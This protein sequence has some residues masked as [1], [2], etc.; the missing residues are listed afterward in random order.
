MTW[1]ALEIELRIWRAEG[2]TL[3]LWWRDDDAVAETAALEQLFDLSEKL[4]LPLHLAVIPE[5]ADTGLAH[6]CAARKDIVPLVHGWTHRNHALAGM[7]KAEFGRPRKE[8]LEETAAGLARMRTLFGPALLDMFVPPWNRISP[9]LLDDLAGQ[10][11]LALSTYNTRPAP[12]AAPGLRQIN[13]HLDPIDWRGTRSL[14]PEEELLAQLIDLLQARRQG[15]A[16]ANEPLGFLTHHLVH[17]AA[18]WAF[19]QRCLSTLLDGGATSCNLLKMK[20][21]LP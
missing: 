10:G 8:A 21:T 18:I 16:D 3:P 9:T 6:A 15:R 5:P 14:V 4:S 19:T 20:E 12:D 13:T 17:D 2:L 7:K 1:Q 11:Y